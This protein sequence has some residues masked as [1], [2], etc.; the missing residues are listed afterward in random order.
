MKKN[1]FFGIAAALMMGTVALS[2]CSSDELTVGNEAQQPEVA[3]TYSFSIQATMD[4]EAGTRMF[5]ITVGE[6]EGDEDEISSAFEE[7][8]AVWVF[9]K[10]SDE[11]IAYGN[12]PLTPENV[13]DDGSSCT[14]EANGLTFISDVSGFTPAVGDEVYLYYGM[15]VDT[16][17]NPLEGYFD[18]SMNDGSKVGCHLLDNLDC[19]QY[20]SSSG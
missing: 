18:F 10:R 6:N 3:K 1:Y 8:V 9:I 5:T 7:G 14:L 2:S 13:S 20:V 16:N 17:R 19:N 4:D 15:T 12:S 11:F